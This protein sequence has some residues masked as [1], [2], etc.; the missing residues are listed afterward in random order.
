MA[1]KWTKTQDWTVFVLR[2]VTST[3]VVVDTIL[4]G[5][6]SLIL[7]EN[8][9]DVFKEISA[10]WN[11]EDIEGSYGIISFFDES[12]MPLYQ[13]SSYYIMTDA[14]GTFAN[15]SEKA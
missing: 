5:F 2:R 9:P 10:D 4:G 14:G 12:T 8:S 13:G 3:G 6:Y 11:K 7:K 15:I 1:I